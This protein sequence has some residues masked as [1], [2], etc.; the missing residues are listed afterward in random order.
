MNE[1]DRF[2]LLFYNNYLSFIIIK[3]KKKN[4]QQTGIY[5]VRYNVRRIV[6]SR[7]TYLSL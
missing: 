3:S 5:R 1:I 2:P 7:D 4:K 6:G